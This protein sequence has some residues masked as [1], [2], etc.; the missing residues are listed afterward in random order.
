MATDPFT[1]LLFLKLPWT[2]TRGLL[3]YHPCAFRSVRMACSSHTV[4]CAYLT[5]VFTDNPT[6]GSRPADDVNITRKQF[7]VTADESFFCRCVSLV[8]VTRFKKRTALAI[9][10]VILGIVTARL[11]QQKSGLNAG[12]HL[13]NNS[14]NP[15][16]E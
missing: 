5:R 3:V 10:D 7:N 2:G 14:C 4:R 6:P 8:T 13:H 16:C 15:G 12:N 1:N 11:V 9:S